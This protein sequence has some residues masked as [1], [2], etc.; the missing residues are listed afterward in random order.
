MK[1]LREKTGEH[2]S[3]MQPK[4][5]HQLFELK[6]GE[7]V[8]GRL[9]F[10]KSVGSLAEAETSDGKWTFKRVGF[11]NTKITVRK[12][13]EE[14]ELA[15]FKPNLMAK[16]GSLEFSSGKKFQ[17]HAANFWET[18]FE[19]KDDAGEAIVTFQS[20]VDDPKLKDWFKTQARVEIH[21]DK[22]DLEELPVI[23]LLG[24]YLIIVL[25]MDSSAGAVVAAAT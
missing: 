14:H 21:E 6:E 10:P 12:F 22:K 17:W 13:G 9:V 5:T 15:V 1:S 2:L 25:Q 4:A 23:V 11:F 18:K 3:W 7:N 24:W 8:F 16:S 19:L 20:G